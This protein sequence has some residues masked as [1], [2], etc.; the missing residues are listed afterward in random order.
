[1]KR[2]VLENTEDKNKP[3]RMTKGAARIKYCIE[4]FKRKIRVD[5]RE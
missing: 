1:M 4:Q 3:E 2:D 5:G